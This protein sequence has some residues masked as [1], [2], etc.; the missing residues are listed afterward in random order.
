[1]GVGVGVAAAI[2]AFAEDKGSAAGTVALT[3]GPAASGAQAVSARVKNPKHAITQSCL[4]PG[5]YH[6]RM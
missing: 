2:D 6:L 1:M 5:N 3:S 4:M